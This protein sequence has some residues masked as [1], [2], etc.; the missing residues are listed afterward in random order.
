MERTFILSIKTPTRVYKI[1][2]RRNKTYDI[3]Y[4]EVMSGRRHIG[5]VFGYNTLSS[6]VE[7]VTD[8]AMREVCSDIEEGRR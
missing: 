2:D 4:F 5:G 3:R 8:I 7:H 6:A 1:Y